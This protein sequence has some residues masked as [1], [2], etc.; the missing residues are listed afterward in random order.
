MR[1]DV[2]VTGDDELAADF[3][4]VASG[5][6]SVLQKADEE[7]AEK[8]AQA[9]QGIAS[10]LGGVQA[11]S[12][13]AVV[14]EPADGGASVAI[15]GGVAPYALGAAFGSFAYAQFPSYVGPDKDYFVY[16]ALAEYDPQIE[17]D[18]AAAADDLL[19][20]HGL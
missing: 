15:D 19:R 13:G 7:A 14:S 8:V 17:D 12:S 18:Y 11:M 20:K 6:K 1:A 10:G 16:P 3:R 9:A 5:L 2:K 4:A